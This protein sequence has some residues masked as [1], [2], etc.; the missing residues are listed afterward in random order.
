[1]ERLVLFCV[2]AL[3]SLTSPAQSGIDGKWF[4]TENEKQTIGDKGEAG[5]ADI[6]TTLAYT[7]AGDRYECTIKSVTD[8]SMAIESGQDNQSDVVIHLV[9]T[10]SCAGSCILEGDLLTLTP[11]KKKKPE[12]EVD[13]T[14]TGI[15]GGGML[16]NMLAAPLKKALVA[17]LKQVRHYR[18]LSVGGN[19]LTLQK[20]VPGKENPEG[21]KVE[22]ITLTK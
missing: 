9:L 20:I 17:E 12:V 3:M 16:K 15:A 21:T 8:M 11:D 14:I 1:M 4:L 7:F 19:S 13:A 6:K 2:A 5:V 18:V 22:T 10:A